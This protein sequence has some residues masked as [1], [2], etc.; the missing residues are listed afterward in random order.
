ML[1]N[2]ARRSD[3]V[4]DT[5]KG[6]DARTLT[7]KTMGAGLAAVA[8]ASAGLY[9]TLGTTPDEALLSSS[10]PLNPPD[11]ALSI[12]SEDL[13]LNFVQSVLGD[14]ED[15]W[16]QLFAQTGRH[17]PEPDADPVRQ[18]REFGMRLRRF[19]GR[20]V[21]LPGATRQI[22]LDLGVLRKVMA[23]RYSVVG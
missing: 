15:T 6:K 17:Y 20:P 4:N 2:K 18:W 19:R 8:L 13:Q 9:S 22:Y 12:D 21:L 23:Q 10:N 5:R 3:N 1:W 14:T 16:K 11:V 7:G